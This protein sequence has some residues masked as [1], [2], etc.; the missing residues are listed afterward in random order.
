MAQIFNMRVFIFSVVLLSASPFS[1][2][3]DRAKVTPGLSPEYVELLA[4]CAPTVHPETMSAVISAESRGNQFAIADAGPV[5][6]PWSQRKSMV[7]SFYPGS[8]DAAVA[9][10]TEL[11]RAGHT[12][13]LGLAQINDRNLARYGVTVRDV[14]DPCTN[15]WVGGRIL[16]DFYV[17][18]VK[19]FGNGPEA[20]HASLSA[21]NSGDWFRGAKDGYVSLVYRQAGRGLS[22]LPVKP[23]QTMGTWAKSS[24]DPLAP[25][26]GSR[27][28]MNSREFNLD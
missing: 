23:S 5:A 17:R 24:P 19:K 15:V 22:A 2:A 9:K 8:A 27:F 6:L 20:L 14:F 28:A 18:A 26:V 10:A 1:L 11:I 3:A 13:S 4:R 7:R 16:T 25:V 12:V 21:Y